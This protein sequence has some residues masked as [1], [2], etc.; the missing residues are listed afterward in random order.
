MSEPLVIA[1]AQLNFTVG[2]IEGNKARIQ[3]AIKSARDPDIIIFSELAVVGYPPEDL[4]MRSA[5]QKRAIAAIEE[6]ARA[7]RA[8]PTII[9]GGISIEKEKC[10]NSVYVLRGGKIVHRQHKHKLPNYGVFDEKRVFDK[11]ALPKPFTI[12]GVKF[13]LLV[14]EDMW[15][16]NVPTALKT[17]D[18]LVVINA[19]PFAKHKHEVRLGAAKRAIEIVKSPLIYLNQVG[20][21]D[22]IVFDGNSFVLSA[23][24]ELVANLPSWEE[25]V[26]VTVWQKKKS[27]WVCEKAVD[28]KSRDVHGD[29]YRAM[30]LALKDYVRKNRFREVV[31]GL[32]GGIDSALTAAVAVDALGAEAVKGVFMPSRFTSKDSMEDAKS[33]AQLL[34]IELEVIDIEPMVKAFE[35]QL[36]PVFEG[37]KRDITEENLQSRTRGM[38]LMAI[39][40]KTGAMVLTTGNKSELATGYATLYGDMCGGYNVLKDVYKTEVYALAKWRNKNEMVIPKRTITKAP[41]AELRENQKDQDTLPSYA[42]LDAI[43][44]EL[45]EK[46]TPLATIVKKGFHREVV[47]KVA[48]MLY[49]SEYKRRQAAPGVKIS[50]RSFGRDR[51]Y[52]IT[53]GFKE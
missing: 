50:T 22:D 51:R 9:I 29:M 39:S 36:K 18:I 17:A 31:L 52:P 21:Q 26:A 7:N 48:R 15:G 49:T 47:E 46:E 30:V 41:T 3:S 43:L 40:N 35:H 19:S 13:G 37:K 45:I 24:G 6:I 20:G 25:S 16:V 10:F 12:E 33:S 34:G 23:K 14:C 5:F 1:L 11:G 42:V 4:V 44:Q 2:D 27:G 28:A 38:I 8:G 32:S 53:N